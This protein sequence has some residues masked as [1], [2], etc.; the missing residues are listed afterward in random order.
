M[1]AFL[2]RLFRVCALTIR[3]TVARGYSLGVTTMFANEAITGK[4]AAAASPAIAATSFAWLT[5][6]LLLKRE[7]A[8]TSLDNHTRTQAEHGK[9]TM[10][11][12]KTLKTSI[13]APWKE[14]YIEYHKL[15]RLLREHE[16]K[17]QGDQAQ[18]TEEDEENFVQELVNVQLD[19]VNEF[20]GKQCEA[21]LEPLTLDADVSH[22]GEEEKETIAREALEKLDGITKELSELEK[23]SRIN[24]T[25]FLKAAKK[26]DRKR[27]ARY[28][29]RPLLQV[30]LSQLPF[31]SEDYSPLLY[32][33]SAMYSF[34]RQIL[35]FSPSFVKD[36]PSVDVR[37][38]H[39]VYTSHKFWVHADN[40]MEVKT[41]ILRRLPVLLY[42][43]NASKDLDLGQGDPTITSLY[44]DNPRFDLYTQKIERSTGA[45]SLRLR[46]TG[47]L[48]DKPEIFLEKKVMGEGGS[49]RE[50][51]ISLKQK[52]IQSFLQ[53]NYKMD[54][55]V[56]RMKRQENA[57]Q[58]RIDTLKSDIEEIQGFIRDNQLQPMVRANYT[59]TAF[60]IPG[61]DRIRISLDTDLALIRE[62]A[63]DPE[64]PCRNPDDWHRRDIDDNEMEFPFSDIKAAEISRFPHAL[65]EIKVRGDNQRR[66]SAEWLADLMSSHLVKDAPRFS[67][68]VHGIAQLFEDQINSFPFWLSE[69]D[70]DIRRDP[71]TAFEEE[72]EKIAKRAE[73]QIAIGSFLGN[74]TPIIQPVVGSPINNRFPS[75]ESSERTRPRTLQKLEPRPIPADVPEEEEEQGEVETRAQPGEPP[76]QQS[77]S[78]PSSVADGLRSKLPRFSMSRYARAHRQ[79]A[80]PLPP[81]VYAPGTWIKDAGPV[82]VEAKVWLANQRTF[83]KWQHISILLAALSLGLYNAAGPANPI[84]RALAIVYTCFAVFAGG[85]G[86]SM[87][88]WRSKLIRQRSGRDFDNIAGPLIVCLGLAVALVLNFWFKYATVW[89]ARPSPSPPPVQ[90]ASSGLATGVSLGTGVADEPV[91]QFVKQVGNP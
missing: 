26:H 24:F 62:D 52:R 57:D 49:S 28:K 86:W 77:A 6:E 78:A 74:K 32:R 17:V 8:T 10:R 50:V 25:G 34:V 56:E 23:F 83:I 67:K 3:L 88:I 66:A 75:E 81:G 47:N 53:G 1:S 2:L 22:I 37:L 70:T 79:R 82:R 15:K 42:N 20:Q 76:A 43:P 31:N 30:R 64:R 45:G 40:I 27:G 4:Q 63:L 51:R 5:G 69:L 85:W 33:L 39:D 90:G 80:A 14:H 19:K 58:N 73:D 46:W 35:D 89:N 21:K 38:G 55:I 44:F 84:A 72:Q 61:D 41:Y 68:F 12:G 60:Q 54:K 29:V 9:P 16:A 71:Q 7:G 65:L 59:R 11:F 18:W 48:N 91:L 87:Y 36:M 13:Y